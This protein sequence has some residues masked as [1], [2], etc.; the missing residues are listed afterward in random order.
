VMDVWN[1]SSM[2]MPSSPFC[3]EC[4]NGGL[5]RLLGISLAAQRG[6]FPLT[7]PCL[8]SLVFMLYV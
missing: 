4:M 8:L 2:T 6:K 1:R 3:D 7:L 5:V